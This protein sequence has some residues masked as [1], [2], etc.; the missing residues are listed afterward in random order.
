MAHSGFNQGRGI[1]ALLLH[2]MEI[3]ATAGSEHSRQM[4]HTGGALV[5]GHLAGGASAVLLLLVVVAD[6]GPDLRQLVEE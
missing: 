2:Q 6:S 1:A 3:Q 4:N 5:L